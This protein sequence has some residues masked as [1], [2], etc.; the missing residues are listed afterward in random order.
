MW[1][2]GLAITSIMD[3]IQHPR[4]LSGIKNAIGSFQCV[5]NPF[6]EESA[7]FITLDTK[8]MILVERMKA[9]K[10]AEAM[11]IE[12]SYHSTKRGLENQSELM[13]GNN[14]G[15]Q[16]ALSQRWLEKK[17]AMHILFLSLASHMA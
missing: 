5:A 15:I 11:G 9:A 7:N 6:C 4:D 10:E 14:K 12:L 17:I 13:Y 2:P 8:V 3:G 1:R 16:P